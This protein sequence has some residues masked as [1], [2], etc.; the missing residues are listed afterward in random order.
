M[1]LGDLSKL[2][3]DKG[4]ELRRIVQNLSELGDRRLQLV[5]FGLE[6]DP[7]ESREPPERHLE[8]VVGLCL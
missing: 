5:P 6:L 4:P 1:P 3:A 2:V 7:A 8:D